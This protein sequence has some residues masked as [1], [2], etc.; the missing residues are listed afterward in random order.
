[1]DKRE[2]LIALIPSAITILGFII[3][4]Y[5]V[6]KEIKENKIYELKFNAI[7]QSMKI[8][9]IYIS[10]LD[11]EDIDSKKIDSKNIVREKIT[12]E[13]LTT[14]ARECHNQLSTTCNSVD[15]INKFMSIIL[16]SDNILLE[17]NEYK[18][19]CREELGM[20]EGLPFD[21]EKIFFS[22]VST[23]A[24]EKNNEKA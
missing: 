12:I 7:Q 13:K 1:M 9:D 22:K 18:N 16:N 11:F 5:Y 4:Y 20:D 19:L 17:Y 23:K 3:N 15:L 14:M 8:L 2:A 24:L 21:N 6:T 10:W